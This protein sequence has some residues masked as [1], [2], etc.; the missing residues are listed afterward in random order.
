VSNIDSS[1]DELTMVIARTRGMLVSHEVAAA[2][3]EQLAQVARDLVVSAVGAG[4]SLMDEA[5]RRVSTGTTDRIAATADE[6]QYEL[7]Q[8]PC[9]S[10]WATSSVQRLDDTGSDQRWPAW[11]AAARQLGIRSVLSAPLVFRA[12]CIGALK[13]YST[14]PSAFNLEDE[15]RLVLMSAAAATLL[16]M[17]TA[18]DAPQQLSGMLVDAL[19]DRQAIETATGMLMERHHMNHEAA[20]YLLMDE[21]RSQRQPL[22]D[23]AR[24]VIAGS[25]GTTR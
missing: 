13:V 18:P 21:S 2:A 8:G 9:I 6:L 12:E 15:R 1:A 11:S 7:G 22:A 19:A 4:A 16:G 25:S 17:A 20:R 3:V 14:S 5:G 10:A 23:L 24:S